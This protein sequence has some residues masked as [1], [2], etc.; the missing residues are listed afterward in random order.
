MKTGTG[1]GRHLQLKIMFGHA[2]YIDWISELEIALGKQPKV[3]HIELIGQGEVPADSALLIRSVLMNRSP[4]TRLVTNARS[5]LQGGSVLVWLLGNERIIRDDARLYFRSI[6]LPEEDETE[7]NAWKPSEP[8]YR[9]S[10][11]EI[12]PQ[13]YD[14]ARVLQVINEFLPVKELAGRIIRVPVLKQFGLVD[15]EH[16][17]CFLATAFGKTSRALVLQ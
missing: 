3:L 16:V 5:S 13:D 14:Y 6:D 15:N 1:Q 7:C 12:D 17:D 8:K 10:F 11:S 2:Y 9:D 4:M